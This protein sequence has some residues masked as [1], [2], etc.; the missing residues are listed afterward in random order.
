MKT[1]QCGTCKQVKP[2]TE[3]YTNRD[4]GYGGKVYTCYQ[5]SCKECAKEKQKRDYE[6]TK[7]GD[8]RYQETNRLKTRKFNLKRFDMTLDD[9]NQM[10]V[11]QNGLC[12]ICGKIELSKN[13]FGLRPLCVDHDHATN[14]VRGL[15]CSR[16]N[17]MLGNAKDSIDTLQKAVA[18]LKG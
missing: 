6:L 2:R 7:Q 5:P 9:Y 15:L 4:V 18:Y 3:F 1:K 12:A 13:Q 14:K 17:C 11:E 16:C 10:L 8:P